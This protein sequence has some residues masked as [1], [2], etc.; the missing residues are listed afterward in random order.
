MNMLPMKFEYIRLD[1]YTPEPNIRGKTKTILMDTYAWDVSE[2]P[3]WN[4]D[5][6]S[7]QQASGWSSDCVLKPVRVYKDAART[8]AW[9]VMC[10][11]WNADW[12]PHVSNSRS[13]IESDDGDFWFG[14]EQEYVMEKNGKP[15]W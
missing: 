13:T 7:T 14:F 10:E 6:S 3:T 15:I 2:L 5:W 4:F 11:V 9:I 8:N 1:G 12:T